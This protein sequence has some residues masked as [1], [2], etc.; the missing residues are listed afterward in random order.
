MS[1]ATNTLVGEIPL[2]LGTL[3]FDPATHE[4]W[5]TIF[6]GQAPFG[7]QHG[8]LVG[9]DPGTGSVVA[10]VSV[11]FDPYDIAV[12]PSTG[13]VYADGCDQEGSVCNSQLS[14]ANGASG[15]LVTTVDLGSGDYPTMTFNPMTHVVY[16]SGGQQLAAINGTT[17][18]V[19]FNVNPLTCGPFTDMVVDPSPNLVLT[20]PA[21]S[22]YLLAY[23]GATGKLVNMY[24]FQSYLAPVAFDPSSGEV[25]V[26]TAAGQLLSI[27]MLATTGN[28]NSTLISPSG[29]CPLP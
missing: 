18:S 5:G 10:N 28:V 24:W 29:S 19:I 9:V 4:L 17:G 8:S 1:G 6:P 25:Y 13:M 23:D 7:P 20:A 21:N 2:S 11:G 15:T 26:S 12:D 27:R 3:A 16:V 14:I 22:D